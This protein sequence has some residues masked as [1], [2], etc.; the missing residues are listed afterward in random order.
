MIALLI[1]LSTAGSAPCAPVPGLLQSSRPASRPT[2]QPASRPTA[3]GAA[4]TAPAHPLPPGVAATIDGV[5]LSMERYKDHLLRVYGNGELDQLIA[6]VLLEREAQR[7][8]V[9]LPEDE[10]DAGVEADL[11]VMQERLG[12]PQALAAAFEREGHTR[13]SYARALREGKRREMLADRI[14]R[15]RREITPALLQE[16]FE[17]RYGPGG[18]TTHVQHLWLTLQRGK[19]ELESSGKQG[20]ELAQE[21][22]YAYLVARAAK[23]AQRVAD[24][25]DFEA[26]ARE[27][28]HDPS[29]AE[30][31]GYAS[32]YEFTRLSRDLRDLLPEAPLGK[33][34]GPVRTSNG[35]FLFRVLSRTQTDFEEVRA[36]LLRG[37]REK[38]ATWA[39]MRALEKRLYGSAEIVKF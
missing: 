9:A 14:C 29:V 18:L 7:V 15:S 36:E 10:L 31:G 37:L 20:D 2:S 17:R 6:L 4:E 8:G 22:V 39:E 35:V 33:L 1:L 24:G 23:L 12:G 3:E 32:G 21:N 34:Q 27:H 19:L 26:L 13:V 38:P 16:E 25:E 28:S 5:P 30:N 11:Q